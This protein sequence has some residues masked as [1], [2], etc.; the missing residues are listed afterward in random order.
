MLHSNGRAHEPAYIQQY[1]GIM[2]VGAAVWLQYTFSVYDV[3]IYLIGY[4]L[5]K[6]KA[7]LHL[8]KVARPYP[9]SFSLFLPSSRACTASP[10]HSQV[11]RINVCGANASQLLHP[12]RKRVK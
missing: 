9:T 6:E 5:I 1:F 4:L 10:K 12:F 8:G 2:H 11:Y 3:T 7:A